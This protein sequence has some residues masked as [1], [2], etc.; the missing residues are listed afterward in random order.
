[1]K[2]FKKVAQDLQGGSFVYKDREKID[3]D[4]LIATYPDGV[5][6]VGA[7]L[8]TGD[9]GIYAVALFAE[10]DRQYIN[11]GKALTDIVKEWM[12]GYNDDCEKM[13]ADLKASGGVKV[14]FVKTKTK[15]GHDFYLVSIV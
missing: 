10:N 13:S 5:T 9:S 12:V 3:K 8:V 6:I 7:D 11:G 14:K 4:L 15:T 1:M 2:D